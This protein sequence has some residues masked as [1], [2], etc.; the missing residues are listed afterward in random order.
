MNDRIAKIARMSGPAAQNEKLPY[1]IE[2][3]DHDGRSLERVLARALNA[4]LRRLL[5][6]AAVVSTSA[7][8]AHRLRRN[9]SRPWREIYLFEIT[10]LL[11]PRWKALGCE[12]LARQLRAAQLSSFEHRNPDAHNSVAALATRPPIR[13][14]TRIVQLDSDNGARRGEMVQPDNKN[15]SGPTCRHS[16]YRL[17]AS[18]RFQSSPTP[19]HICR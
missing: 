19:R 5:F 11:K 4:S 14:I 1:R 10:D 16:R 7:T 12:R 2:L 8:R 3:W 17:R 6:K 15:L 9:A 13:I 18:S